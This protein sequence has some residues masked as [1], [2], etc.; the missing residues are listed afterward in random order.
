MRLGDLAAALDSSLDGD[1]SVEVTGVTHQ[2]DWARPG[3]AFV[4]I[5]GARVDG[6]TFI[7]QAV[8]R[9]AVAVLG[10]GLPDGMDCPVPYVVVPG[11]RAALADAAAELAGHPSRDLQVL[12][13]TGTDGKTTTSCLARHLLRHAG[14]QA[15]LLSTIGY[16][17]PDGV[18]RQ[19]P[20]H[21]TTPEAPQVQQIL[22][23][24]VA[25]GAESVVVESSSH[26]LALDRV[27]AVDFDVAVWTN[28]TGEHLDFHGSME[29]YF[30]D[31]AKL[32]QRAPF[33]VLNADDPWTEPLLPMAASHTTYSGEGTDADWTAADVLEG[34]DDLRFTL[35]TPEGRF[36]A[37]LPMI[38]RFN[39]ANALAA[40][41]GV[42]ALGV[43]VET[44]VAGLAT[45]GGVPGR[46]EM[47]EREQGEPRV[48]V[49]FAHTAPSLEKALATVRVTT[50]GRLWV[51]LGSAGGPR[52]P[53]KRA[54]LGEAATRMADLVVFTE[55]DHR[56]TPL[57]DILE[58][59]ER[60]AREAGRD[61]FVSIGNRREAIEYVV[62]AASP[63]DT[64]VLAGKG[65]EETLE[66]DTETI[67][68]DEMSEARRA[69]RLRREELA[70]DG[71]ER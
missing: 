57:Q 64:I 69:L 6:H 9:G 1:P 70:A 68:W 18:L 44:L 38:G 13:V 30:A 31:K 11:A 43:D 21:F 33:A 62:G 26:A 10:E 3:D 36:D 25:A 7:G 24:E 35:L 54:P 58:E 34:P 37:V 67:P 5:R 16:E 45:F 39:V 52:D 27:R 65:P 15:G 61:N 23:D 20:T 53:S 40:V 8:E 28:L 47:V 48:I 59:M 12:G 2:A 17:L 49:D 29:G 22:A 51:L 46:M 14:R 66:R 42:H 4:A 71:A 19:P 60:G 63:S 50:E 32:V 41:A 56:D 55:E